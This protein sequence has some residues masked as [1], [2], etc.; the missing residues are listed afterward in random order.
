M[1]KYKVGLFMFIKY[2]LLIMFIS[3][4]LFSNITLKK[5]YY[6]DSKNVTL[7]T[8]LPTAKEDIELFQLNQNRHSKRVKSKE[9][10]KL[11]EYHGFDYFDAKHSYVRFIQKSPIDT[12]KLENT[13]KQYYKEHYIDIDIISLHV[14][15]RSYMENMPDNYTIKLRKR[16]FLQRDGVISIKTQ[17]NKKIFFN[18]NIEATIKVFISRM[19]IRKDN[20]LSIVN[21]RQKRVI[22]DKFRSLPYQEIE[23]GM[24]QAKHHIPENK[25]ITSRDIVDL[26]LVKRKA[27]VAI[28]MSRDNI[29]ISFSAKAL[30]NGKLNDIIKVQKSNGKII[31]VI[32]T[33][34]NTAEVR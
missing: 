2:I 14:E 12:S 9:L 30:Q 6:T 8:L 16:S 18:Y 15:P 23:S 3:A 33:G 19:K 34:R 26:S 24:Y 29:D 32:V 7:K 22:L 1:K 13:I 21:L 28:T 27:D 17:K 5:V 25:I 20:E 10:L 11:L 4:Q 31:K